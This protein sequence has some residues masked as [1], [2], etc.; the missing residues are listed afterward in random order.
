MIAVRLQPEI[1]ERLA[2]LAKRTGRTKTF[3]IREAITEH[4]EDLEDVYLMER[5]LAQNEPTRPLKE[6]LDELGV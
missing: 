4:L 6:F 5:V 3:Y 1:E 2:A